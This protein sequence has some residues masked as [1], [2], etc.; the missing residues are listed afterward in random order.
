MAGWPGQPP[1]R[2][3]ALRRRLARPR[4]GGP[5]GRRR[6]R[7]PGGASRQAGGRP[8][9]YRPVAGILGDGSGPRPVLVGY[10]HRSE[11]GAAADTAG[12]DNSRRGPL[13]VA[14]P[15]GP[16]ARP[17]AGQSDLARAGARQGSAGAAGDRAARRAVVR[18]VAGRGRAGQRHRRLGTGVVD[19]AA[20]VDGPVAGDL[21][22]RH[23]DGSLVVKA[24]S[25]VP[26]NVIGNS[27]VSERRRLRFGTRAVVDAA[28]VT[29]G[30]ITPDRG[31]GKGE[32]AA[33]CVDG[34][35][36]AAGLIT[37][38]GIP[39]VLDEGAVAVVDAAAVGRAIVVDFC[40]G[41]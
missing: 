25:A 33:D 3:G 11:H 18:V 20:P 26:G 31:P 16:P 15:A 1:V 6:P 10:Q 8:R 17:G 38:K 40:A 4:P 36:I 23:V 22:A 27:A 30:L 9:R 14:G 5:A 34:A 39:G 24:A 28:A 13:A 21:G 37:V 2:V 19:S 29:A 7:G 35:A 32:A 41:Y 12:R